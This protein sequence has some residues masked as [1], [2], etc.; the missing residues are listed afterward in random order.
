MASAFWLLLAGAG[1]ADGKASVLQT[2][3]YSIK[4]NGNYAFTPDAGYDGFSSVNVSVA[5]EAKLQEKSVT[6]TKQEQTIVSDTGYDGL[7]KIVVGAIPASYID[8]SGANAAAPDILAPKTAYVNGELVTGTMQEYDGS[9]TNG[10]EGMKP[11]LNA[12]TITVSGRQLTI[13]NPSTNGNFTEGYKIF[14]DGVEKSEQTANTLDL[15][16]Y[17]DE[18]GTY[19]LSVAA[20]AAQFADS[21][22]SAK[23]TYQKETPTSGVVWLKNAEPLSVGRRYM[24]GAA[25]GKFAVF[26]GGESRSSYATNLVD[27]FDNT[28]VRSSPTSLPARTA[29]E[30]GVQFGEN[31]VFAGGFEGTWNSEVDIVVSYNN[32]LVQQSVSPL[33]QP[34]RDFA[35][36]S[37]ATHCIMGGGIYASTVVKNTDAYDANFTKV[38][39]EELSVKRIDLAAGTINNYILFAGGRTDDGNYS[40]SAVVDVYDSSLTKSVGESLSVGRHFLG[41]ANVGNYVL[42]AGGAARNSFIATVDAYDTA[43][44]RISATN[45]SSATYAMAGVNLD[46]YAIMQNAGVCNSYDENLTRAIVTS[47]VNNRTLVTVAPIGNYAIF[48]GGSSFSSLVDVYTV[49]E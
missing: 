7:S 6:P 30:I 2:K 15:Y 23:A 39:I 3:S 37:G 28:L 32:N 19:Q 18:D 5:V 27:A 34:R 22:Q 38:S 21:N 25:N 40:S 20:A 12:P 17:F 45:L 9:V 48:A 31:A 8:T 49:K 16:S 47:V 4:Q 33:S 43:L 29:K 44:T 14:V 42:F 11:Q 24:A 41:S 46:G 36:A 10:T 26:A 1:I 13:S 35:A